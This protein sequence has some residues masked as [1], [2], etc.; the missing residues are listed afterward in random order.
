MH[1]PHFTLPVEWMSHGACRG[2]DPELSSSPSES[3][4][5]RCARSSRRKRSAGAARCAERACPTPLT[6]D[7]TASEEAQPTMNAERCGKA[8]TGC[9][10]R[11]SSRP[12]IR[13]AYGQVAVAGYGTPYWTRTTSCTP[14]RCTRQPADGTGQQRREPASDRRCKNMPGIAA[15]S[16]SSAPAG[17]TCDRL[18]TRLQ[19]RRPRSPGL[20]RPA[21]QPQTSRLCRRAG[22]YA[23]HEACR[24]VTRWAPATVRR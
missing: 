14:A 3:L 8:M 2:A 10:A 12:G 15:Q 18:P 6:P 17:H 16:P 19:A 5:P 4:D 9:R 1:Q 13:R 24:P 21:I 7:S 11:V 23:D 20:G 22:P